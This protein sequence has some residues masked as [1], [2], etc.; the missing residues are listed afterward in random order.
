MALSSHDK[1]TLW[2]KV[3]E[4][5]LGFWIIKILTSTVGETVADS[6]AV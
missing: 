5:T 3:P 4:I 1:A 6:L 2:S